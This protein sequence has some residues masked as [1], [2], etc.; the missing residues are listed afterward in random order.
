MEIGTEK[1]AM[2]VAPKTIPVKRDT[3]APATTPA[4][5]EAPVEARSI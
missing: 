1:E 2:E 3:P 4:P 5:V